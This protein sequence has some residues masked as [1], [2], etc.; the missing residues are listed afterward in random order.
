MGILKLIDLKDMPKDV[1]VYRY[2]IDN[3]EMSRK[4]I[5]EHISEYW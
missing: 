2:D 5:L 3:K 1:I 4:N